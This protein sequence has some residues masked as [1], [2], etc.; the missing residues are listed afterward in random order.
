MRASHSCRTRIIPYVLTWDGIVTKHH[1]NYTKEIGITKNVQAYI[2]YVV[3]KKT[4]ES[5]S[6]EYRREGAETEPKDRIERLSLAKEYVDI[7][8]MEEKKIVAEHCKPLP[9]KEKTLY[10]L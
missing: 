5:I 2:Q 4:L 1:K 9:I 8:S 6:L 10:P 7:P 3:L